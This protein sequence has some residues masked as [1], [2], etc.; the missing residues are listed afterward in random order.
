MATEPLPRSD[1][2][3]LRGESNGRRSFGG[4][5]SVCWLAQSDNPPPARLVSS[6]SVRVLFGL[7]PPPHE[8]A[9]QSG[10]A[11]PYD[12]SPLLITLPS[13]GSQTA[14]GRLV[15]GLLPTGWRIV[16]SQTTPH[17]L[18]SLA[19]SPQRGECFREEASLHHCGAFD[20]APLLITLPSGGSQ[21]AK[22][23]GGGSA[24]NQ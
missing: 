9:A 18:A 5:P 6:S 20:N 22:P 3:P 2:S 13:G 12:D 10:G 7:E 14:A 24:S 15:G 16:L 23:F 4:G 1:N 17:Q 8:G 21:T 19:D 11:L